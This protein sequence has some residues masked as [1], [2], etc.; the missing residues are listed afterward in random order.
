MIT[1]TGSIDALNGFLD[2]LQLVSPVNL[3]PESKGYEWPLQLPD[4][5]WPIA[6]HTEAQNAF[7]A[8]LIRDSP[9]RLLAIEG[10]PETGKSSLARQMERN[11]AEL[12]PDLRCGRFDFKG[13]TD[14]RIEVDAFAQWFWNGSEHWR[15]HEGARPDPDFS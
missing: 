1:V 7:C 4:F 9:S 11:V 8:L 5:R 12:L 14:R 2:R 6:D 13:T 3:E 10:A 15:R